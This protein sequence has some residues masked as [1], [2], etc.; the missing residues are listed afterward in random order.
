MNGFST[1]KEFFSEVYVTRQI[2]LKWKQLSFFDF[3]S[4]TMHLEYASLI[5]FIFQEQATVRRGKCL[6]NKKKL[7]VNWEKNVE[8]HIPGRSTEEKREDKSQTDYHFSQ[9]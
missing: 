8:L 3:E 1:F 2:S 9:G 5:S 4:L 6:L 7:A